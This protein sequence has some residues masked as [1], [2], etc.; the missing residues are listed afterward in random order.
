LCNYDDPKLNTMVA[1]VREL[2]ADSKEYQKAWWEM[3]AYIVKNGLHV[4]LVWAPN[5]TAHNPDRV[6]NIT[7]RPD[8]FGQPRVDVFKTYI[9]KGA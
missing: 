6:G 5:I 9:K 4:Y 3:D 1:K 2:G 7:Y 8:V